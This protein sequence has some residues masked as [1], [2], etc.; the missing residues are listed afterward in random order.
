MT[1]N[2]HLPVD[3]WEGMDG[4]EP[5]VVWKTLDGTEREITR[6]KIDVIGRLSY[7]ERA[8][9][10]SGYIDRVMARLEL[11]EEKTHK[12]QITTYAK[13]FDLFRRPNPEGF[14]LS[15][16][17][18]QKYPIYRLKTF[19]INDQNREFSLNNQNLIM[20]WLDSDMNVPDIDLALKEAIKA[21]NTDGEEAV[22]EPAEEYYN[23]TVRLS[24]SEMQML[25]D[26]IAGIV[27]K[28]TQLNFRKFSDNESY[29]NG[30]AILVPLIEW[31]TLGVAAI[32]TEDG[33]RAVDNAEFMPGGSRYGNLEEVA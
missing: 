30:Q 1:D 5:A 17:D 23:L 21:Q 4:A 19:A 11:Q 27:N 22:D 10:V 16:E 2:N 14:G 26:V 32:Q 6:K 20:E 8:H 28:E 24:A 31:A 33:V 29:R 12:P 9:G 13:I 18:I 3:L 7:E 25:K 15:A